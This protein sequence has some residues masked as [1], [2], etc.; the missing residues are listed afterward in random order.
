[1]NESFTYRNYFD[2]L[3]FM[4]SNV[5]ST[6][7][8]VMLLSVTLSSILYDIVYYR[9]KKEDGFPPTRE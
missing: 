5:R 6:I 1:M 3:N 4:F 2:L 9:R 8:F 7:G